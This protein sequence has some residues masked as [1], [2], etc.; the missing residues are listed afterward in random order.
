MCSVLVLESQVPICVS[1]FAVLYNPHFILRNIHIHTIANTMFL[2]AYHIAKQRG[3]KVT[4]AMRGMGWMVP[5]RR[6]L[7]VGAPT[8]VNTSRL[9]W[10]LPRFLNRTLCLILVSYG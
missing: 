8:D 10:G 1:L 9:L 2:L 5:R 7:K 6:P 4:I 3:A